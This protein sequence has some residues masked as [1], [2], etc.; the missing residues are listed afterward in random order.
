MRCFC[1]PGILTPGSSRDVLFLAPPDR[2]ERS[3]HAK[4]GHT[5][6]SIFNSQTNCR[7]INDS[8]Y[9][10]QQITSPASGGDNQI[11]V[12]P[13]SDRSYLVFSRD[14]FPGVSSKGTDRREEKCDRFALHERVSAPAPQAP[15]LLGLFRG[16]LRAFDAGGSVAQHH[17]RSVLR[18]PG[19]HQ[20]AAIVPLYPPLV[21]S[22]VSL[23]LPEI[24]H[25][26]V[27]HIA[28]DAH[29]V[30]LLPRP[31]GQK[32]PRSDK[33]EATREKQIRASLTMPTAT[34]GKIRH[35]RSDVKYKSVRNLMKVVVNVPS[36]T[37]C[38]VLP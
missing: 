3:T 16:V 4:H 13:G 29:A 28:A 22:P 7:L 24:F 37:R 30:R 14:T 33:S 25:F 17:P 36:L 11:K 18:L 12:S 20:S 35:D 31:A 21:G 23:P 32:C 27:L 15:L 26:A 9:A 5:S 10:S 1:S 2:V 8:G 19:A 34:S 6:A 38:M